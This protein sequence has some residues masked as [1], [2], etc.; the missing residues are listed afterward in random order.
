MYIIYSKII[1]INDFK[2]YNN[3]QKI[4]LKQLGLVNAEKLLE[5]D[6]EEFN[7]YLEANKNRARNAMKTAEVIC[8]FIQDEMKLK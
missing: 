4:K 6:L 3:L 7:E 1:K 8:Y 2:K 5:K